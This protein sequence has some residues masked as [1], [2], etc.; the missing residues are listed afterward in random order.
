MA[1][2][3]FSGAFWRGFDLV[4]GMGE[5]LAPETVGGHT[6]D[7]DGI[8]N[9]GWALAAFGAALRDHSGTLDGSAFE[10]NLGE[11]VMASVA[12]CINTLTNMVWKWALYSSRK[13]G[14]QDHGERRTGPDRQHHDGSYE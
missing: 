2:V 9:T 14:R 13:F 10:V 3:S 11:L 7:V 6:W 12:F 8:E 5:A 4:L 1:V